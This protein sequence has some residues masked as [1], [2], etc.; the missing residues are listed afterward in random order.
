MIEF[1]NPERLWA[2]L[3]VPVLALLYYL[4]WRRD[5]ARTGGGQRDPLISMLPQELTWK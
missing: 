5:K 2:L 3:L 1:L 4:L